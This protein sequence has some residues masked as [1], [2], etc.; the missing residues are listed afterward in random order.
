MAVTWSLLRSNALDQP[1]RCPVASDLSQEVYER[2]AGCG[3]LA[4]PELDETNRRHHA[5]VGGAL[6]TGSARRRT[7][8]GDWHRENAAGHEN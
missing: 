8:L 6:V 3:E 1:A 2:R 5:R 4:T 7:G